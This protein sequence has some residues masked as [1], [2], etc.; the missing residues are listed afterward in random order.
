MKNLVILIGNLGAD[1]EARFMPSGDQITTL[2]LG[3]TRKWKDKQGQKVEE[4]EW[5]RITIFGALAKVASDYLHKG[6]KVYFEGRIK[7]TKY[8]KDGVDMYSTG[9]IAENMVMLDGKR[10]EGQGATQAGNAQQAAG[11]TQEADNWD[12]EPI[13][14]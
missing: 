12:E 2:S 5:H 7:T 8:Q 13:P 1:P 4:T 10:P 3:T 9:I 11:A 6:S 14:F